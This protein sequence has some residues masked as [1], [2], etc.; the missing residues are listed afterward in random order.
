MPRALALLAVIAALLLPASAAAA[1]RYASPGGG[2]VPGCPQATPC[3]LQY[4]ISAASPNDEVI[5]GPGEYALPATIEIPNPLWIHGQPGASLPRIVAN[6]HSAFKSFAT[7]RLG[8]LEIESTDNL[9]GTLFLPE[10]GTTLERLKVFA[11]GT[12]SPLGFRA[13]SSFTVTDSLI[14]AEGPTEAF[15]LFTQGASSGSAQLRND[16]IV[17]RA[18]E[19]TAV[20]VFMVAKDSTLSI[21]ATN[22]IAS[23]DQFDASAR[24]G[25]GATG[26]TLTVSFDHSNLDTTDGEVTSNNGQAAPPQFVP[27]GFEE[28]P[29]S[30]TIDAGVNDAANGPADLNGNPRALPAHLT[31][32][33]PDL[34]ITDIGAY[35]LV[36][37]PVTCV[38]QTKITKLKK[39][40]RGKVKLRFKAT[41]TKEK[42]SFR[43]RLDKRRWRRC[44]SPKLYKGLKPGRHT[45]KV[46]AVTPTATDPTPAKRK[47]RIKPPAKSKGAARR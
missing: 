43:C 19:S 24:K 37:T 29:G 5:V 45:V 11:R 36:P 41:G 22:T 9:E 26:S 17:A 28:A 23:G 33:E 39:L 13:G 4:A 25:S 18:P 46:R 7:Q 40:R 8:D 35:E 2:T 15:G 27:G 21:A 20:S 44:P 31:C 12:E 16:T 30:P 42:A 6:G 47:F 38:P 10:D 1:T 34:A 32:T 14:V 3:S